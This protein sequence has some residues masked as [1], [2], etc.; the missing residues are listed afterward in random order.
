VTLLTNL[1]EAVVELDYYRPLL[2]EEVAAEEVCAQQPLW[3]GGGEAAGAGAAGGGRRRSCA[4]GCSCSN[5]H[6]PPVL[7]SSAEDSVTGC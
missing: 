7:A 4:Y 3:P 2:A 5:G 1:V 6:Q